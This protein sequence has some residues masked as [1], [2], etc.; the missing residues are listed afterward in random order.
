MAPPSLSLPLMPFLS[1]ALCHMLTGMSWPIMT[2]TGR[3]PFQMASSNHC[4][5][6]AAECKLKNHLHKTREAPCCPNANVNLTDINPEEDTQTSLL[7]FPTEWQQTAERWPSAQKDR[8]SVNSPYFLSRKICR[9]M[10]R[11]KRLVI[12][13]ARAPGMTPFTFCQVLNP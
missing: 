11:V 9:W 3:R 8:T 5:T 13:K 6:T 12:T 4:P 7:S 10:G 1:T 2:N